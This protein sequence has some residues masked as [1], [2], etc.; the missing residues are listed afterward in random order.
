MIA[1]IDRPEFSLL[2]QLGASAAAHMA[3]Q[4]DAI[5][6]HRPGDVEPDPPCHDWVGT[7]I[8]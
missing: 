6:K 1:S 2:Q 7:A 4:S 5:P 8:E 3:V